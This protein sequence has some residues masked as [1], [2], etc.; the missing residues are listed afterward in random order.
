[1]KK[2][3]SIDN[4]FILPISTVVSIIIIWCIVAYFGA[5]D[6]IML[7][8]PWRVFMRLIHEFFLMLPYLLFTLL[9]AVIGLVIG[10]VLAI[11]FSFFMDSSP[12]IKKMLEPIFLYS[13]TVPYFV[14]IPILI[15]WL[16]FG[17]KPTVFIVVLVC[18]FPVTLN[19]M[20]ALESVSKDYIALFESMGATK[21][22]V[23]RL[24]KLPY[25]L[26]SLISGIKISTSYSVMGA[27]IGEW[28][29]GGK[30]IGLFLARARHSY[31]YELVLATTILISLMSSG[32]YYLVEF[33]GKKI[34]WWE[35]RN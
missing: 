19:L 30:G 4:N 5:I 34:A 29:S 24:L 2:L 9:E 10:I 11:I 8:P 22:K 32:M 15:M 3:A 26:P 17:M 14:L 28:M 1:M 31:D 12:I 13:Q 25:I 7:P 18:F 35:T 27:C 16:G 6:S 21:L 23:I 33:V 20:K